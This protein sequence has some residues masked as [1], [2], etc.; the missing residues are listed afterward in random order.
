MSV[1]AISDLHLSFGADKSM[2][3]FGER[4]ANYAEKIKENWCSTIKDDDI[5]ILPGDISWGMY[6]KEALPDFKFIDALPGR[7]IILKGNH[8]YW[9]STANKLNKFLKD[10]SFNSI[11]FLHN[12]SYNF[13]NYILCGTRGW[14]CPGEDSFDEEDEKIYRRELNRLELSL[15]SAEGYLGNIGNII[16]AMHFPPFNSNKEPSEFIKIMKKFNVKICVYGHLHGLGVKNAFIGEMEGIN[17]NIVSADI[18][19]F[20]PIALVP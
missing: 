7:K 15:N 3:I 20:N 14:K 4:W 6:L 18:I 16:V 2:D 11:S 10:N 12:N 8:D 5:V 9:W 19:D 17:F 1:Y 13:E